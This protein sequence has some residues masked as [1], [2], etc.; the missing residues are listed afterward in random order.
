M[1]TGGGWDLKHSLAIAMVLLVGCG[2]PR[3]PLI[4]GFPEGKLTIA[5]GDNVKLALDVEIAA[6]EQ[7]RSVGLMD[8]DSLGDDVGMVFLFDTSVQT[9]FFMKDTLIELDIA[10]WDD[11]MRVVDI[12]RMTPCKK[13]PCPFYSPFKRYVGALEVRAGSVS[14]HGI[15]IG[16]IVV[17]QR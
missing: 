4:R 13:E 2:G 12:L 16:D 11:Q 6:T 3:Q 8:I 15:R 5:S 9:P 1:R 7:Q 10:F 17:L 14:A